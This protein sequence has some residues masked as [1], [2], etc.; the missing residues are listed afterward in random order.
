MT[1][2]L[3]SW[4][5]IRTQQL[6]EAMTS[7]KG[8]D[9]AMDSQQADDWGVGQDDWGVGQDDWGVGQDDWGEADD[10]GKNEQ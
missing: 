1:V 5:V 2:H 9:S 7:E 6:D 8:G 10:G 4:R 3:H